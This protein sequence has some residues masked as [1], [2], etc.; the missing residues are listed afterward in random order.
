MKINA[1]NG[2]KCPEGVPEFGTFYIASSRDGLADVTKLA[3]RLESRGMRDAFAW[4]AHFEHRC[5]SETCGVRDRH[6]LANRELVA[7]WT[8]DL[9]IGIARLGK[10][11]HVELG[12]ALA[13]KARRVILV[14]VDRNDSVFYA[15]GVVEVVATIDDVVRVLFAAGGD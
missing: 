4:P 7:A 8:C 12:A 11:S 9:F 15:D 3:T 5:S 6:D 1:G 14:G 13:G 2:G 10:G